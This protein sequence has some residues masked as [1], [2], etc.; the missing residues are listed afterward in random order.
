MVGGDSGRVVGDVNE[1]GV[2]NFLDT[3]PY[4][5]ALSSDVYQFEAD[6]NTDGEV[7]FLDTTPYI[8]LLS[9]GASPV[10]IDG[11]DTIEG[12]GFGGG[13]AIVFN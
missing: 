11:D 8:S 3:T 2:V 12:L 4:I 6:T 10:V 9:G 7:N 1:D 13:Q 5:Q